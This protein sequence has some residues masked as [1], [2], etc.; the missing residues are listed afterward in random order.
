MQFCEIRR[1]LSKLIPQ[2]G[3]SPTPDTRARGVE[4]DAIASSA[5][6][7]DPVWHGDHWQNLLSSPMDARRYI[8]EDWN[9]PTANE[10]R[11][12]DPAGSAH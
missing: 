6:T 12:V 1:L 11:N 2:L 7:F 9:A 8:M 10:W 4:P 3:Q 5:L